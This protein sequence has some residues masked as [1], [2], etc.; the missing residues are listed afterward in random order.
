MKIHAIRTGTVEVKSRQPEGQ[1]HGLR[2]RINTLI[3]GE[4]AP[5]LPIWA[6]AIEHPEG[7]IVVDTGETSRASDPGYYP[8]WH[9]YFRFGVRSQV[10]PEEEIGPQLAAL[11]IE[12]R[13]VRTV[14]M[15]H[16]HTDHA[17]GLHHFRA[18]EILVSRAETRIASGLAGRLNGYLNNHFPTWFDPRV[19][20]LPPDPFGP[21][22]QSLPLTGAG[23]VV[24][25]PVPGHTPGQIGVVIQDEDHRVLLAGDTSYSQDLMLRGVVDG[26]SPDERLART[27]LDRVQRFVA[28]A[29]TV[30]LVAH[31]PQTAARLAA[32]SKA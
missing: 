29:P 7:V 12:P 19:V 15:T 20:D 18:S 21:F 6:F 14:V 17:G 28:E 11:G 30:Y 25:V 4:W 32:R 5:P 13:D 9:P 24:L 10:R 22:P 23:D 27:T 26:V 3:D 31:D 8:S 1:G 16:L 2:R